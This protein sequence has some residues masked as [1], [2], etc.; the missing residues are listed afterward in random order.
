MD[1][2]IANALPARS[3]CN[4]GA[5]SPEWRGDLTLVQW[6]QRSAW[7]RNFK[8]ERRLSLIWNSP[9]AAV[10]AVLAQRNELWA[11]H[12]QLLV[13]VL[14]ATL[15]VVL[16]LTGV[17]SAEAGLPILSGVSGY[18]LAK[19]ASNNRRPEPNSQPPPPSGPDTAS[20]SKPS[21]NAA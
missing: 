20:D 10:E 14:M 9:G 7:S 17:I 6:R 12:A 18:A 5:L 19:Q 21:D 8:F 4:E 1:L 3:S 16:L 13:A 11:A 15:L 2:R